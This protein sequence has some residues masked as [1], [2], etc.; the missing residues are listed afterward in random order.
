MRRPDAII[1]HV[2]PPLCPPTCPPLPDET[3][4]APTIGCLHPSVPSKPRPCLILRTPPPSLLLLRLPASVVSHLPNFCFSKFAGVCQAFV[5]CRMSPDQ[6]RQLVHLIKDNNPDARTLAVGDGANDVPMI[7]AAH[8]GVGK[9]SFNPYVV[10]VSNSN[11][12]CVHGVRREFN[13]PLRF[14]DEQQSVFSTESVRV[15]SLYFLLELHYFRVSTESARVQSLSF[16][17]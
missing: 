14:R 6:K 12:S 3:G 17:P 4:L 10:L 8:V 16:P 1:E 15:Q 11:L 13:N 9:S 5:G 7:Q 2:P